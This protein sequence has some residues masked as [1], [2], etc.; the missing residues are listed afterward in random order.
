MNYCMVH[1][2]CNATVLSIHCCRNC[3]LLIRFL[4]PFLNYLMIDCLDV[5]LNCH[6]EILSGI[7]DWIGQWS[8]APA[9]PDIQVAKTSLSVIQDCLHLA[10]VGIHSNYKCSLTL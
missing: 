2:A 7:L 3:D 1:F 5:P 4:S 9:L 6:Y 8:T 10:M